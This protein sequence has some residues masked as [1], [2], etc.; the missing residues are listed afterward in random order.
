MRRCPI[1]RGRVDDAH[2]CRRCGADLVSVNQVDQQADALLGQAIRYI[3][4]GKPGSAE[5]SLKQVLMLK[6]SDFTLQLLAFVQKE[7]EKPVSKT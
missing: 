7:Y 2:Q 5:Q 4:I 6:Q 3:S 1:C